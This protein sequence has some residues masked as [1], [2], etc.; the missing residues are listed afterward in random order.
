MLRFNRIGELWSLIS[1]LLYSAIALFGY[2]TLNWSVGQTLVYIHI[3][4]LAFFINYFL[5]FSSLSFQYNVL[6]GFRITHKKS[7]FQ[8]LI[9]YPI[10]LIQY[11]SDQFLFSIGLFIF[12]LISFALALTHYYLSNKKAFFSYDFIENSATF[13]IV[14]GLGGFILVID[15]IQFYLVFKKNRSVPPKIYDWDA[16][17]PFHNNHKL[18]L[19][20]YYYGSICAIIVG[21]VI[22]EQFPMQYSYLIW[23]FIMNVYWAWIDFKHP[24]QLADSLSVR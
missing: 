17:I 16:F 12:S 15:F 6:A 1:T 7:F 5:V 8:R 11:L 22:D 9:G 14:V 10:H 19:K 20:C 13:W 23:S 18:K 24:I 21:G 3:G 2:F 4:F